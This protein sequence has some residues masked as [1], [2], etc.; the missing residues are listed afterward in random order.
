VIAEDTLRPARFNQTGNEIDDCRAIRSTV[1]QIAHKDQ[2]SAL[3]MLTN[4]VVAQMSQQR[5]QRVDLAVNIAHD[6]ETTVEK[7]LEERGHLNCHFCNLSMTDQTSCSECSV[8]IVSA[9][10]YH[11]LRQGKGNNTAAQILAARSEPL[12]C[13]LLCEAMTTR[14]WERHGG[15]ALSVAC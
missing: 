10:F 13:M 6:V 8:G 14:L 1:C 5:P 11:W 7:G 2:S 12:N 9:R 15:M 4:P 3:G